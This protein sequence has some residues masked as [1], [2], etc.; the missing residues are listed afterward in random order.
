M[1]PRKEPLRAKIT[2]PAA[3]PLQGGYQALVLAE[4]ASAVLQSL[5]EAFLALRGALQ[6]DEEAQGQ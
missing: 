6:S 4:P 2:V 3:R 5:K 1:R